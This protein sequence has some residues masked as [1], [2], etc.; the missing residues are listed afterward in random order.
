MALGAARRAVS[1]LV[2]A[3]VLVGALGGCP[4]MRTLAGSA[5]HPAGAA[6]TVAARSVPAAVRTAPA[7]GRPCS[8]PVA[9]EPAAIGQWALSPAAPCPPGQD[10]A[11]LAGR[12][13]IPRPSDIGREPALPRGPD[14]LAA[15]P[16]LTS[17]LRV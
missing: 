15:S 6:S 17:L 1:L 16:H 4:L 14:H 8:G 3:L 11:D 7:A 2:A 12:A 13:S 5:P 10:G 9:A